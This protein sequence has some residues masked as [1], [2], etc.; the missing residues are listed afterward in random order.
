MRKYL[1][2]LLFATIIKLNVSAQSV[3]CND[4][5]EYVQQESGYPDTATSFTSSFIKKVDYYRVDGVGVCIAYIKQNDWD[6]E[7]KPYIFCGISQYT[8]SMFRAESY[9][10]MGKAFNKYIIDRTCDCY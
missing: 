3:S 1:L 10:S 2:L 4:L 8:W 7:G 6:F 5:A 9:N